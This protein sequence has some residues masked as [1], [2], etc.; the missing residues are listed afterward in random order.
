MKTEIVKL[1]LIKGSHLKYFDNKNLIKCLTCVR[2]SLIAP[3]LALS[4]DEQKALD[5]EVMVVNV[6]L[7]F[8]PFSF[9]QKN[10]FLP[11]HK[12]LF[13]SVSFL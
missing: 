1:Y 4:E 12:G 11:T 10:F 3:K 13:Q 2:K 9:S 6:L 8:T 7:W 5:K